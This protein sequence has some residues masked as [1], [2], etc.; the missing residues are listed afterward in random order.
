VWAAVD[1][2]LVWAAGETVLSPVQ[3]QACANLPQRI[4]GKFVA[5]LSL[6]ETT[7][8]TQWNASE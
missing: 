8:S 4:L 6:R 1:K 2:H 7:Y 3:I 5:M